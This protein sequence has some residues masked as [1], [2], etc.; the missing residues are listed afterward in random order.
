MLCHSYYIM[1]V[2]PSD[3]IMEATMNQVDFSDREL[4][5]CLRQDSTHESR[6]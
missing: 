1:G 3:Y 5:T 4:E 2:D 6:E